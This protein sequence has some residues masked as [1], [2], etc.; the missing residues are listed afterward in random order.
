MGHQAVMAALAAVCL[1]VGNV[2]PSVRPE[3]AAVRALVGRASA[4]SAT[5]RSLV[6]SLDGLDARVYVQFA[7]CSGPVPACLLM[8]QESSGPRTFVA[9]LD[10]YGRSEEEL[11]VLLAHELQHA[12]EI[13]GASDVVDTESLRRF[14]R[15]HGRQWTCGFETPGAQTVARKVAT[16]LRR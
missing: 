3:T 2:G 10:R 8:Q 15:I 11:I 6:A 9:R 16:E 14:L 7:S 4:R 5:F 1:T 13:A 12:V